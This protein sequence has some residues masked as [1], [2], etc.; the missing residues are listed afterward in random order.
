MIVLSLPVEYTSFETRLLGIFHV[1]RE[2]GRMRDV[3]I[4][5]SIGNEIGNEINSFFLM[6]CEL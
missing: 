5:S 6:D 1:K 2:M 3:A 4:G